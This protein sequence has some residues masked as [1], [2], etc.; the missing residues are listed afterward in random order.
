MQIVNSG[1]EVFSKTGTSLY[2]PANN[3]TLFSGFGGPCEARNDGDPV[4]L[5]D[6]IADRWVLTWFT[7]SAPYM[8]C[9]AVSASPDPTLSW[10]RYAFAD[11]NTSNTLGD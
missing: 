7:S 9:I 3:N 5:Y 8:E 6:A 10:Y 1:F 2:G 11:H 4:A